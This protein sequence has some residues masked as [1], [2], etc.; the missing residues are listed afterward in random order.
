MV[1]RVKRGRDYRE[2]RRVVNSAMQSPAGREVMGM[3][4]RGLC[5]P[6]RARKCAQRLLSDYTVVELGNVLY[7]RCRRVLDPV[8]D[9]I[10]RRVRPVGKPG[11]MSEAERREYENV[12]CIVKAK[13]VV[14]GDRSQSG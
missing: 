1:E 10:L 9:P 3:L 12:M 8:S 7:N 2:R 14:E 4:A 13:E 11:A 6:H 5:D